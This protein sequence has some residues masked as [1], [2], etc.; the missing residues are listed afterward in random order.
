MKPKKAI[1]LVNIGT[2]ESL[3]VKG[4]GN[5]L[6]KFLMDKNVIDI[7]FLLRWFLVK[8]MI[9]P[10]RAP[11]ALESYK[12]I[13]KKDKG[14]PLDYFTKEIVSELSKKYE[15]EYIVKYAMSYSSPQVTKVLDEL[16]QEGVKEVYCLPMYPQYAQSSTLC[17]LEEVES[18]S[19]KNSEV[20]VE[21][22]PYYFDHPDFLKASVEKIQEYENEI[23]KDDTKL[24]FSFHGIPE[25]HVLSIHGECS[26]GTD[27]CSLVWHS[28]N[29]FCYKAQCFKTAQ[30]IANKLGLSDWEVSF[31]SRLGRA[32]WVL[33]YTVNKV[34]ELAK[35]GVK[36]LV[37]VPY[38][39]TVDCLETEEEIENEIC[40][41]FVKAGGIEVVR[42]PCLNKDFHK[43]V[44][45]DF[46][47]DFRPLTAV[48]TEVRSH[49]I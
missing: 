11:K 13:W 46:L 1:L 16:K 7:P 41:T 8:I 36:R 47:K 37:V 34:T 20:K 39:F 33:P 10:F 48:M 3:T 49:K 31:Q 14:S 28:K 23:L 30:D 44:T 6:D 27:D 32:Q 2:P 45:E 18:W 35:N 40:D 17:A 29:E 43:V 24:L 9:I 42:V 12:Y 25:K 15:G 22:T 5:F 21:T 38:A 19:K 26:G 4:V